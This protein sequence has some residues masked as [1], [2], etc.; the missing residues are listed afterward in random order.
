MLRRTLVGVA[1]FA[2]LLG[3]T[4][5]MVRAQEPDPKTVAEIKEVVDRHDKALSEK[6]LTA[7]MET[8]VAGP[9]TVVLGTGPGERWVGPDE[10]RAAYTEMFKNYDAGTLQVTTTW[11]TGAAEGNVAWI[12][13]QAQCVEYL[14]NEK[15]EY[16]LNVTA[17][18]VKRGAKWQIVS[19][20]MSNPT[21]P[22]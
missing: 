13:A 2:V 15:R 9:N 21:G 17:T 14:K 3:A 19:L 22:E 8:F 1:I 4:P 16:G 6:N 7:L 20:H 18:L 12:A 11:K 5:S 10:I